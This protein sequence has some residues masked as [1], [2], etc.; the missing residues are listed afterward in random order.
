MG[1]HYKDECHKDER[2]V[3][4]WSED[5]ELITPVEVRVESYTTAEVS[6][7]KAENAKLKRENEVLK[8]DAKRMERVYEK[9]VEGSTATINK[10]KVENAKLKETIVRLAVK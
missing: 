3:M 2:L 5:K 8:R 4:N 9:V 1:K 6:Q 7:L 10:W